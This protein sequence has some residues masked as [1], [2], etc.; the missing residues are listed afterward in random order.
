MVRNVFLDLDNTIFDFTKAEHLA[1]AKTLRQLGLEP[2]EAVLNRYSEINLA[3]WKLLELGKITREQVKCRRFRFLFEELG[4]TASEVEAARIYEHLL[5][6]GH[7]YMEGAEALL[8]A[9]RGKYR[10]YLASNGTTSVQQGRLA[11]AGIADVFDGIFLSES[12]GAEKPSE[13]FFACCF[14][15]IPDFHR[16]ETVMVGDS[17]T[18]DIRGGINAGIR[19]IWFHPQDGP[20]TSEI[21]PDYEIRQ[22]AELPPLLT[23]IS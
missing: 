21:Q 22:L 11:S 1:L 7:Y 3:Q 12:I 14:S 15:Q 23:H 6:Q 5:G 17:L 19:T 10:L 18:S 4:A 8:E 20:N 13:Q 2:T 9:L 16:E